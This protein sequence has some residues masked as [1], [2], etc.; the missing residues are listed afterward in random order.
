MKQWFDEVR[1]ELGKLYMSDPRVME[2]IGFT[3]FADEAGFTQVRLRQTEEF[4][5]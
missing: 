5:S 3:G 4:E 1:G 2:R